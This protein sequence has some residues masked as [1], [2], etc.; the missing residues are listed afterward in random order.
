MKLFKF[1]YV[2][3]RAWLVEAVEAEQ[4]AFFRLLRLVLSQS[5]DRL[6][7]HRSSFESRAALFSR[8]GPLF[9][10]LVPKSTPPLARSTQDAGRRTHHG[11]PGGAGA[12]T[13]DPLS[14][15]RSRR[16]ALDA[17]EQ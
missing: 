4:L 9:P 14:T 13:N 16:S 2:H 7:V 15:I 3:A 12:R 5:H 10:S 11:I 6:I 17:A 1:E 8:C